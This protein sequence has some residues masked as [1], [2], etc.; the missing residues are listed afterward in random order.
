MHEHWP[1]GMVLELFRVGDV[2]TTQKLFVVIL[3][4]GRRLAVV[5]HRNQIQRS[6]HAVQNIVTI[7]AEE[8][9]RN[10]AVLPCRC[11]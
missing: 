8:V 9:V 3:G 10:I 2:Y 5:F 11:P 1:V 6:Q 4:V 7:L